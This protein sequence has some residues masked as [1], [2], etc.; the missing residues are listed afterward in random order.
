MLTAR[1]NETRL[2]PHSLTENRL[3]LSKDG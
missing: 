1:K 2:M 3:A